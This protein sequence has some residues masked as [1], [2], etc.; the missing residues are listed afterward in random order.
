M[1]VCFNGFGENVLTFEKQ[2]TRKK[3]SSDK[4]ARQ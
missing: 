4:I 2:G 3:I 1:N